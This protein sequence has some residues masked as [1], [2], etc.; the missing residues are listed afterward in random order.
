[1]A[2]LL[3]VAVLAI[4]T[5]ACSRGG[6]V[7]TLGGAIGE[8]NL[9]RPDALPAA[10]DYIHQARASLL[11]EGLESGADVREVREEEIRRARCELAIA[12]LAGGNRNSLRATCTGAI[13][14]EGG[15]ADNQDVLVGNIKAGEG[16]HPLAGYDR[17]LPTVGVV[18][19]IGADRKKR[20]KSRGS[21]LC[22]CARFDVAGEQAD[23]RIPSGAQRPDEFRYP[24]HCLYRMTIVDQ[25]LKKADI[26]F[27]AGVEPG[28]NHGIGHAGHM[29]DVV[30]DPRVGLSARVVIIMSRGNAVHGEH[31]FVER[32][33]TGSVGPYE[34]TV[35]VEE[36]K[37]NP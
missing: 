22:A 27:E 31:G 18:R 32:P 30:N 9:R 11:R 15:I 28:V 16:P 4:D 20:E 21:Q 2:L 37:A 24:R 23:K 36:E 3:G 17:K 29:R 10:A 8:R 26:S 12:V 25:F 6:H 1:M 14:V 7:R 13:H 5:P 19:T 33:A 35:N 34:R